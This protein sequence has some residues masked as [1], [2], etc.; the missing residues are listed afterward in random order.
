[1][2][3]EFVLY[4]IKMHVFCVCSLTWVDYDYHINL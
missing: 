2:Y 4:D 3:N 1:M